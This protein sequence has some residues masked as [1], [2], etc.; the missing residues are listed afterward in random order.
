[1]VDQ[2]RLHFHRADAMTGDV[3]DVI[4]TAEEPEIAVLVT[5]G[6][7]AGEV[8]PR[9]L[10]P[11][12]LLEPLRIAPDPAE[13]RRPWR[14]DRQIAAAHLDRLA[15]VIED[16]RVDARKGLRGRAGFRRHE[17]WQRR[18][19]D[20]PG[21]G[22]PPGIDDRTAPAADVLLVPHPGLGIDRLAD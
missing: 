8:H 17:T 9:P 15:V 20:R 14:S 11:V 7:V 3:D 22:L 21:L 19:H 13:H 1:M 18:D 2:R 5:L 10:R 6:A 12:L 4:D 16:L